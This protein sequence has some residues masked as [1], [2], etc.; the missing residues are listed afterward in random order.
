[1]IPP[2]HD[3]FKSDWIQKSLNW[4]GEATIE[5]YME[6]HQLNGA[7]NLTGPDLYRF[8]WGALARVCP[9]DLS[10]CFSIRKYVDTKRV[11]DNRGSVQRESASTRTKCFSQH[12]TDSIR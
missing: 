8:V 10:F 2:P 9:D 7:G 3:P 12:R 5:V 4:K 6:S 11:K 1:M